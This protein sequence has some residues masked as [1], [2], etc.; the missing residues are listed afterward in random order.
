MRVLLAALFAIAAAIGVIAILDA[1]VL[2]GAKPWWFKLAVAAA[3]PLVLILVTRLFNGRS[4]LAALRRQSLEDFL[5]DLDAR[6]DLLRQS[7]EAT[8]AFGVEEY[9]DGGPHYFIELVSGQV[10]CLHGPYLHDHEPIAD[11]PEVQRR[12]TF[13]CRRFIVLRRK[14]QGDVVQLLCEGPVLE[15]EVMAPPF[16]RAMWRSGVPRD[17]Q[18]ISDEGYESLKRR[19]TSNAV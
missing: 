14:S 9:A 13:P 2:P 5:A 17:G 19:L 10:L 4:A 12:R 18:V 7:F 1:S 15:P 8:R 6:G 3:V 16:S 11:D